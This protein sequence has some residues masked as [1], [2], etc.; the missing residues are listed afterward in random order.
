LYMQTARPIIA[1]D[2]GS[3]A[4]K[5]AV[6]EASQRRWATMGAGE[7]AGWNTAYQYNLRLYN[8][9]VHSY[10][11]GNPTAKNMDDSEALHYAEAHDIPL[12]TT[13][14]HGANDQ[15]AIAE[16]L[17]GADAHGEVDDAPPSKAKKTGGGR[18]RKTAGDDEIAQPPQ[19]PASPAQKRRRSTKAP[20]ASEEPK[21]SGRKKATKS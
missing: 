21:K 5:G 3:S 15:A 14:D 18:K 16:Q 19:T 1:T 10:K 7:K 4:P 17:G 13:D 20:E 9:R 11:A 6:Q 2:L 12:P 8:A